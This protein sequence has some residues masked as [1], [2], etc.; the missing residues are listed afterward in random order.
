MKTFDHGCKQS[1]QSL[2][3]QSFE[4]V[5]KH[6]DVLWVCYE[7]PLIGTTQETFCSKVILRR[8]LSRNGGN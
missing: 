3:F 7:I 1:S 8:Y 2:C 4:L 6:P 5:Q